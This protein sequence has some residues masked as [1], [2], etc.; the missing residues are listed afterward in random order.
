MP[1]DEDL[2]DRMK[3]VILDSASSLSLPIPTKAL[4]RRFVTSSTPVREVL[5]ELCKEDLVDHSK[6]RGFFLRPLSYGELV[7]YYQVLGHY[8]LDLAAFVSGAERRRTALRQQLV[9]GRYGPA[10]VNLYKEVLAF[11]ST[12]R[13]AYR[14]PHHRFLSQA[15]FRC[16]PVLYLDVCSRNL[17]RTRM[18][19]R[20]FLVSL[21][22]DDFDEIADKIEQFVEERIGALPQVLE[23]LD[24]HA[25]D[26]HSWANE[27]ASSSD[28]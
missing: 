12:A 16:A 18:V 28:G 8:L 24:G 3:S 23:Q 21:V 9:V 10:A 13:V 27:N 11:L 26:L 7:N 22:R 4:E 6:G 5:I 19:S 1:H 20:K 2:Y 14:Y 17:N 15:L 25:L